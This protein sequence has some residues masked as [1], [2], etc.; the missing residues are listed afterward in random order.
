MLEPVGESVDK[1]HGL[2]APGS[3]I[4]RSSGRFRPKSML[5]AMVSANSTS[6]WNTTPEFGVQLLRR[7]RFHW[8]AADADAAGI[9]LIQPHEQGGDGAL[10]A[11]GA[12]DDPQS[13]PFFQGKGNMG[14]IVPFFLVGETNII[15]IQHGPLPKRWELLLPLNLPVYTALH[16]Y[17]RRRHFLGNT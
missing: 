15:K 14:D 5:A 8:S 11:A 3:C 2:G 7:D 10:S 13:F 1:F 4:M 17:G 6:F 9:P 12:A 16:R